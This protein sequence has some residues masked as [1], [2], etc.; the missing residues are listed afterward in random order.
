VGP[1]GTVGI[2]VLDLGRLLDQAQRVGR[3]QRT[4]VPLRSPNDSLSTQVSSMM[5]TPRALPVGEFEVAQ[6][7][8]RR[9]RRP[10]FPRGRGRQDRGLGRQVLFQS[11]GHRYWP[12]GKAPPPAGKRVP[13]PERRIPWICEEEPE[14]RVALPAQI[15]CGGRALSSSSCEVSRLLVPNEGGQF[16][17]AAFSLSGRHSSGFPG[18]PGLV[19]LEVPERDRR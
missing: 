15:C 2:D 13:A 4:S 5:A 6:A 12:P 16:Q 14:E 10:A 9:R 3:A 18:M 8:A 11:H 19:D 17:L 1:D 7:A